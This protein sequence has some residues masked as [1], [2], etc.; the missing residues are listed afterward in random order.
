LHSLGVEPQRIHAE[1]FTVETSAAT[2][3]AETAA[4]PRV[5]VAGMADVT[6]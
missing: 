6:C 1:H 2:C 3:A 5:A 4:Q